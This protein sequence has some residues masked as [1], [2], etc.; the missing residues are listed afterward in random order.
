MEAKY[1]PKLSVIMPCFNAEAH[2]PRSIASVREQTFRDWRLVV[3]DDGSTDHSLELLRTSR[4]T[5]PRIAVV[6]QKNAGPG[7]ARNRALREAVGEFVAFLDADD[8][9]HPEFLQKMVSALDARPDAGLAYCGWQNLG[10]TGGRGEPFV[11]P[12]Y[13]GPEKIER[14]LGG[15][16]WPI[17]AALVRKHEVDK[18]GRFDEKL[19]SSMDFDLW[20]RLATCTPIVRVP[21]VL[22]FYV[23][24]AG[25]QITKNRA[26]VALNHWWI[27]RRFLEENPEVVSTLGLRQVRHLTHGELL[28]RGYECYWNRDLRAARTIFRRVM[29]YAYGLPRDWI[30][31]LPSLLPESIHRY[32]I[33]LRERRTR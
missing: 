22:A 28:R 7:A 16:R 18:A 13:E 23:H 11:P 20:L 10:V 12:E 33:S 26:R 9:W 14:L 32:A 21:E 2:L 27:Q 6:V 31:M 17:H 24:H 15:C 8:S 3:V 5:D 4:D 19:S 30:Y 25:E 29:R 1:T